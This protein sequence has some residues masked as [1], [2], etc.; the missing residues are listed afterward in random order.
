M[1]R[2]RKAI[3]RLAIG[4]IAVVVAE[5]IPPGGLVHAQP[6]PPPRQ[7]DRIA[8]PLSLNEAA[9]VVSEVT[10]KKVVDARELDRIKQVLATVDQSQYRLDVI[11]RPQGSSAARKT[12]EGSLPMS[13]LV[14]VDRTAAV[15]PP[16]NAAL[17]VSEVTVKKV[18]DTR[19]LDRIKSVLQSVE[20]D[21]YKVKALRVEQIK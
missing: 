17:V 4:V 7:I 2:N 13:E 18:V 14:M 15:R 11:Q 8:R 10:V 9:W 5:L 12:T 3:A 19:E 16:T 6:S 1:Q 20:A 21:K